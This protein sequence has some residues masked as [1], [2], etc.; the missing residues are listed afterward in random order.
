[1][2]RIII[3]ATAIALLLWSVPSASAAPKKTFRAVQTWK[4]GYVEGW[5]QDRINQKTMLLDKKTV[6]GSGMGRGITVYVIDT[7]V[8]PTD[9]FGHGTVVASMIAGDKY[10]IAS[11]AEIVS[12]RA[13]DCTGYGTEQAVANAVNWVRD[14]A[15]PDTSVVNMSLGGPISALVDTAVA[16]LASMMPVVVAAGNSSG[17]ACNMSPARVPAAI[18]IAAYDQYNLRSIFSNFGSCVDFWVPGTAVDGIDMAGKRV[19]WS[20]TSMAA[21]LA[22]GAIA[23]VADRDGS[24]TME[25]VATI[26]AQAARPYL[27][28]ARLNGVAAYAIW[29][30]D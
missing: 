13:L 15:D 22:S 5:A 12:V 6:A 19:Q 28:D 27:V 26:K 17:N 1:M 10:G 18:T 7:G 20:G 2:K 25:A 16:Q 11:G 23:Y 9:C 24:T 14:N 8:G 3:I 4:Q 29:I 21:A 30:R